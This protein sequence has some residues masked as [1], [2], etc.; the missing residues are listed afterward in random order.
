MARRLAAAALAALAAFSA[1]GCAVLGRVDAFDGARY[2]EAVGSRGGDALDGCALHDLDAMA[3][4]RVQQH[5]HHRARLVG[6]RVEQPARMRFLLPYQPQ[7][8]QPLKGGRQPAK[9]RSGSHLVH[10]R[11]VA[12]PARRSRGAACRAGARN[13]VKA[14]NRAA[15]SRKPSI[16]A[17]AGGGFAT[18]CVN[19]RV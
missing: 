16:R 8:G 19:A 1:A 11:R 5:V 14:Y 7:P 3:L 12:V 18:C 9:L 17:R 4:A 13:R 6:E 15:A 10:E 2:D